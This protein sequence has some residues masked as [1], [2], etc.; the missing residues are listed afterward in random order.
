MSTEANTIAIPDHVPP[1]LVRHYPL[2]NGETTY[3]DPFKTIIPA[4]H[5]EPPVRYGPLAWLGV[6]NGWVF[7]KEKDVRAIFMDTEHFSSEGFSPFATLL[8]ES[9]AV[10]PVE[11]DPPM[12]R[13][14]R[15][16]LAPLFT[17]AKVLLM[18]EQ[19]HECA[20]AYIKEFSARGSCD[21]MEDFAARFPISVFLGLFGLPQDEV[22][23]FMTWEFDLLHSSDMPTIARTAAMVKSRLLDEMR[24]RKANPGDDLITL[25]V[26]AE[27]EGRAL[28]EDEAFGICFNLYLGGLDTVTTNIAWQIRHLASD[29]E[30]QEKLRADSSLIPTAVEEMLRAYSSVA[31]SRTCVK[32]VDV[33]GVTLMPGDRV[34]LSTS[35]ASND[36]DEFENP[37][38]VRLDRAT[39]HLGFGTGIHN[40]VGVRLARRELFIA[41]E[42]FL[43]AVPTFTLAPDA[44]ILT[45][46]GNVMYQETV[47]I[48]W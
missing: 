27:Y 3:D 10:L 26:N 47:P 14:F 46:L 17:P 20:R 31:I 11:A 34:M 6:E 13:G 42:E 4:I 1:E 33:G 12:H 41:L 22:D 5:K 37:T 38:E 43:K 28:T 29:I 2:R 32:Q 8:G 18:E 39:R 35:I 21:V 23:Q 7:S 9:W 19:M 16:V 45:H 40:C 48:V 24:A 44:K 15:N 25:I 30:L 36:P